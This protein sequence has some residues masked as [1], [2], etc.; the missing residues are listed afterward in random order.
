M[1][2]GVIMTRHWFPCCLP[3]LL[4]VRVVCVSARAEVDTSVWRLSEAKTQR[5]PT[6]RERERVRGGVSFVVL[7]FLYLSFKQG[8]KKTRRGEDVVQGGRVGEERRWFKKGYG[9]TWG[10]L[11]AT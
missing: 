4:R 7:M 1:E 9:V 8:K 11:R 6:A 2:S 3:V 10:S 5:R